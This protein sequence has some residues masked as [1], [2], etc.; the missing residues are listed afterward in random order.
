MRWLTALLLVV[1]SALPLSAQAGEGFVAFKGDPQQAEVVINGQ[2]KGLLPFSLKLPDG[3]F[4]IE[5][6]KPGY[7]AQSF[8]LV[9]ADGSVQSKEIRL[10]RVGDPS[11]SGPASISDYLDPKPPVKDAFE[12]AQE[13]AARQ[14]SFEQSR[15][16]NIR[17][18]NSFIG[19]PEFA[20]GT[21][22]LLKDQYDINT[23]RFPVEITLRDWAKGKV[24]IAQNPAISADREMAR[25]LY[26]AGAEHPIYLKLSDSSLVDE[27]YVVGN[28]Y[29]FAVSLMRIPGPEMVIVPGGS[30]VMGS[31][32]S[33]PGRHS[34]EGPQHTVK[35]RSFAVG[36]YEV[37]FAEWDA[38]V[39]AGGCN[40]Y[41]PNDNGWGHGNRPVINVSWQDAQ[42]Y[43]S[44]LSAATGKRYRLLTEAEWEYAARAGSSTPFYTGET[45]S[46]KQANY[47]GNYVYNGGDRGEC[48]MTTTGVS[49]F[50]PN[51]FGLYDMHGNAFE[52]VQDCEG[53]YSETEGDGRAVEASPACKRVMRGGCYSQQPV[54]LRSSWRGWADQSNRSD[55]NGIRVAMTPL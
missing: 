9:V 48:L 10:V 13:F 7:E 4:R 43:V 41:R 29:K 35:V 31:P 51:G 50:S 28:G 3:R 42:A 17:E 5:V 27:A 26:A 25:G 37:T 22:R 30:F 15:L 16:A 8:D 52:W 36:K 24:L 34:D 20:A 14:R 53:L 6:R 1:V 18:F 47:C 11:A 54:S 39:A 46:P 12:T 45:I 38:C 23:G 21:A 19:R 33:E 44:W 2:V 49:K 32:P 55:C 40:G